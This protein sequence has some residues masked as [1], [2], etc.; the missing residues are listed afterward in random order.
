MTAS[1]YNLITTALGIGVLLA[2]VLLLVSLM[3]TIIRWKSPQRRGHLKRFLISL[4]AIPGLIGIH[5]A[6]LWLVFLPALGRAKMAE[7]NAAR[8]QRLSDTSLVGVGDVAPQFSLTTIDGEELS[9]PEPGEL[10]LINF[11]AT[12]CGPC[13]KELPQIE[14][15]WLE[16][17]TRKRFR[18]VVIGR[19]ES[20]QSVRDF[21]E[22]QGYSFPMAPDPERAI[23]SLFATELIPRTIVVS[24]AGK[25]VYFKTGFHEE[26]LIELRRVLREELS[27]LE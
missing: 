2:F 1:T 6:I 27:R 8:E 22:Q 18:L 21:R 9:L 14:K 11:F 15:I 19:E 20:S 26:D 17:R 10:V 24:P 23:Y 16:N 12:W 13:L 3:G 5:Q 4:A 25:I 7:V